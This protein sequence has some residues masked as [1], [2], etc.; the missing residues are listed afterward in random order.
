MV[1]TKVSAVIA[2]RNVRMPKGRL[3]ARQR[4]LVS[5]LATGLTHKEAAKEMGVTLRTVEAHLRMAREATG[6]RT[7]AQLV[8][9]SVIQG[10]VVVIGD[11]GR[12]E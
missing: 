6:C 1:L 2:E 4:E 9:M 3:T 10:K 5:L 11:G 7:T 12:N 8:A